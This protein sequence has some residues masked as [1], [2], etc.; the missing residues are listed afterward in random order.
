LPGCRP[1]C[2]IVEMVVHLRL[3]AMAVGAA[4]HE[5]MCK[6]LRLGSG[7]SV[8]GWYPRGP[9]APCHGLFE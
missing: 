8:A 2:K 6:R 7:R 4:H 3:S 1:A 5:G 9:A